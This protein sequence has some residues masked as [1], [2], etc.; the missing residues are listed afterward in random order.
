M[1]DITYDKQKTGID[2]R[3]TFQVNISPDF[4]ALSSHTRAR[5]AIEFAFKMRE[6][7]YHVFVVGEDK[8]GRL[9]STLSYLNEYAKKMPPPKDWVYLNN[10]S[11]SYKPLPFPLNAGEGR[12]LK[13]KLEEFIQET[14][15]IINKILNSPNYLKV[16]DE[17]SA[18]VQFDIDLEFKALSEFATLKGFHLEQEMEGLSIEAN[19]DAKDLLADDLKLIR[20]RLSFATINA[21]LSNQKANKRIKEF[22]STTIERMFRPLWLRFKK[23]YSSDLGKWVDTLRDDILEN[24]D[25]FIN[26]EELGEP[27]VSKEVEDR[28]AVNLLIDNAEHKIP[29][30]HLESNPTFETIFGV[31]QYINHPTIGIDTNF[32]MIK[33]G[34]FH[35]ANDGFLILRADALMKDPEL[36]DAIKAALRD[37]AIHLYEKHRENSL[38]ILNAPQPRPIP[39]NVQVIL[40]SSPH[41]YYNFLHQDPEFST[42]FQI[43]A[44]IDP[45][46]PANSENTRSYNRMLKYFSKKHFKRDISKAGIDFLLDFASR[47]VGHTKYFTSQFEL[48]IDLIDEATAFTPKNKTIDLLALQKACRARTERETRLEDRY[49]D[50]IESGMTLIDTQGEAVGQINALTVLTSGDHEFGFPSRITAQTYVGDEGIINI[51]RLTEMG[52]PIQQKGALILEG[53]LKG[54]FAQEFSL[55]CGCSLTFEQFYS[56]VDGDSASMAELLAIL[57]SLSGIPLRQD[58]SVTGSMNQFG[59]TQAVGGIHLKVEGFYRLCER[60]GLTGKQGVILPKSNMVNLTLKPSVKKAIEEGQFHIYPVDNV[61]EAVQLM[62]EDDLELHHSFLNRGNFLKKSKVF[63]AAYAKLKKYQMALKK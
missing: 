50:D 17:L 7:N 21:N 19:P 11:V 4:Y 8:S 6:R 22:R 46:M 49:F 58:L 31:I 3:K 23:K 42:Y 60:R 30:V 53:F 28:Y 41:V 1:D 18:Q 45:D 63:S 14:N 12:I 54:C 57:S 34:S 32:T 20:E 62:M 51:E 2:D 25:L 9:S 15:G 47:I 35:K 10:F 52:G 26:H 37:Q 38:P 33:P 29:N 40:I 13:K 39:L 48:L 61:F 59:I 5:E 27:I 24:I 56:D 16:I 44:E 55:S 36:W 43:K